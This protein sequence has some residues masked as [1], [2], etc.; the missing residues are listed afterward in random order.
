[1]QQNSKVLIGAVV[2]AALAFAVYYGLIGQQTANSIQTQANQ[3]LGTSPASQQP[4]TPAARTEAQAPAST[5]AVPQNSGAGVSPLA[6]GSAKARTP[7]AIPNF[8]CF[9]R[10]RSMRVNL[11]R[12]ASPETRAAMTRFAV[13]R[14]AALPLV[15]V[16]IA[17]VA[18][19]Q[20]QARKKA[21]PAAAKLAKESDDQGAD[22]KSAK[23][24]AANKPVQ[25]AT[26]GEW[27][28]YLAKGKTKTCYA[29]ASPKER[30][31]DAKHD[32]AFVFIA[33]R[34]AEKVHNEVSIIMGFPIKESGQTQAKVGKVSFDLVAKGAN[35]WIKNPEDEAKFVEALQHGG[36]LIIK[37]AAVK[38]PATTD[39]Y[40]LDGLKPA[41]AR[42]TK[43]C[44]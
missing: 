38:G 42:V 24:D 9:L 13:T 30:K 1:M 6:I 29:L 36:T 44:K 11:T 35:A 5:G 14:Y 12:T 7:G 34:P 17:G 43:D 8:A 22:K 2:A 20:A 4:A 16:A 33:D 28:A 15:I 25:V 32:T 23:G 26:F 21:D 41:L 39:S 31:P 18:V 10:Q 3:T 27:G 40:P 37:A 19:P